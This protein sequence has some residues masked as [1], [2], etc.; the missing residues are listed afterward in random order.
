MEIKILLINP[1]SKYQKQYQII[2][3]GLINLGTI[4]KTH[5][6]DVN[7][8]DI[9]AEMPYGDSFISKSLSPQNFLKKF[10]KIDPDIVGLT[11]FTENYPIAIKIAKM[12]K[13][14]KEHIKIIY[15]G[16]HVTYQAVECLNTTPFVDLIAI[17]ETEH[18]IVDIIKGV[19]GKLELDKIGNIAFKKNGFIKFSQIYTLPDLSL[20]PPPDLDL[21]KGK[22]Y[23]SLTLQVEFSRGC[24]F[25][26]VFCCQ[27][28]FTDRRTRYFPAQRVV[29][30]LEDYEIYF[31]N[32][33][34]FINDPTFL[35][36][37]RKVKLFLDE[38][39][40]RN[41]KMRDWHFETRANTIKKNILKD[42]KDSG[43][44]TINLGIEDIHDSVLAAINKQLKFNQI[45]KAYKIIKSLGFKV[46]SNF[47]I[48]LPSQ[49]K[50]HVLENIEYSKKLDLFNFPCITPFPG[51]PIFSTPEKF[52][53]TLLSKDWES[54]NMKE[55]LMDSIVFPIK[56][57][58]EIRDLTWRYC[59]QFYLEKDF[60]FHFER[61]E[62]Q[63]L[64]ELGF[65]S[66][67]EEWK[68]MHTTSWNKIDSLI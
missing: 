49:T 56:Q 36:N 22:Y 51:T 30:T 16:T 52:G 18:V 17:G 68:K 11:S 54:Y 66:W 13:K 33:S 32:F 29:D 44:N 14:E 67:Y 62:F 60:L 10:K 26:C 42:L 20:I 31:K 2:P 65:E 64:L 37:H 53:L 41:V 24:P 45:E 6:F 57:Q 61:K 8:I 50:E 7:L 55:L 28:P 63:R 23:P 1:P 40:S 3:L 48:G 12:C 9:N 27:F 38:A 4:L 39:K 25:H 47:I 59:A 19:A 43:A 21:I 34:F 15:G 46:R 5:G 35:L 58:K